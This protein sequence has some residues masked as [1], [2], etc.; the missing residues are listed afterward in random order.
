VQAGWLD[1]V[2]HKN[3][4]LTDSRVTGVSAADLGTGVGIMGEVARLSIDY[5]K[6]ANGAP[7]TVVGKFPTADPTNL[8]VAR[9]LFFYPREVA[10]YTKLAQHSPIRTP[11]LLHAELD[12]S[13][14]SFV[15][16][17]EDLRDVTHGDQI[18][19]LTPTQAE[20]AVTA[21]ARLHGAWWGKVDSPG[22]ESLFDFANPDYGAAVQAGYQGFLEPAFERCGDCYSAYT[23]KVARGLAPVAARA[24][25][26][27]S[28]SWRTLLHGDYRADNLMFGEG[29]GQDGVAAVDWQISGKGG[30]LYDVA[31]LICNSMPIAY[32]ERAENDLLH[33]YHDTLLQSGVQGFSFEECWN[34]YRFAV[35]CGLFVAIYT[36]GGMDVGNERGMTAMRAIARRVDAA[37]SQLE[38]GDLLPQ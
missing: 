34:A 33:R 23:R 22:M 2:L 30:A 5:D 8:G 32:H 31:Y 6:P 25:K 21:L 7:A 1:G 4:V 18:S 19:G 11:R 27:I 3:G 38:V 37:V 13:D 36:T 15:L 24:V 20:A 10:F 28:S 9:A 26:Q 14:Q 35:L 12:M 16:L 17:L 29:L